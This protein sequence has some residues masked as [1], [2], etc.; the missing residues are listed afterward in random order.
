MS[1]FQA[2]MDRGSSNILETPAYIP[3][4][5]FRVVVAGETIAATHLVTFYKSGST[6]DGVTVYN[7]TAATDFVCGVAQTAGVSGKPLVIQTK[8]LGVVALDATNGA[9]A[10]AEGLVPSSTAG[11][12]EGTAAN[13]VTAN[14]FGYAL[15]AESSSSLAGSSYILD[16]WS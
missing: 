14:V 10:A 13:A 11:H 2:A 4:R 3:E 15:A 8:G 12:P 5:H 1:D 9:I 16:C 6:M 7:T